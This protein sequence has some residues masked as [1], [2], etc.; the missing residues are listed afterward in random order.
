MID[1]M[2][3]SKEELREY[4]RNELGLNLHPNS[5]IE[6]LRAK[7]A[8]E[9]GQELPAAPKEAKAAKPKTVTI[10]IHP[11][12][13]KSGRSDVFVAVNDRTFLIKRGVNV[14]VPV[15][16]AHVLENA[17]EDVWER[18]EEAND[19]VKRSALAYPFSYVA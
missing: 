3:A 6:T 9:T 16:V 15:E 11:V 12:A 17:V 4:A 7:I 10:N 14:E 5:S 18:D 2:S 8:A 19:L 13:G 1:L